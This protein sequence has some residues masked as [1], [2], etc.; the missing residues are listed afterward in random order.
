MLFVP[1]KVFQLTPRTLQKP[2]PGQRV[3]ARQS[4][5]VFCHAGAHGQ[6]SAAQ[7]DRSGGNIQ[8][9]RQCAPQGFGAAQD[10][11]SVKLV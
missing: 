4:R 1:V 8:L 5:A 9:V 2:R 10:S 3:F 6:V 11:Q 7:V